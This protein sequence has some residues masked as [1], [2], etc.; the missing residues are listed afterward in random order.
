MY[1][2]KVSFLD[3]NL[4]QNFNGIFREV[5]R[6]T[7]E[8]QEQ[9]Y[10]VTTIHAIYHPNKNE[11]EKKIKKAMDT[12]NAQRDTFDSGNVLDGGIDADGNPTTTQGWSSSTIYSCTRGERLPY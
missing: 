4:R 10:D 2:S 12:Y 5:S 11:T 8:D 7:H 6:S 1:I 9:R 3:A